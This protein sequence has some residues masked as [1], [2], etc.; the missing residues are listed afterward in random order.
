MNYNK[1]IVP[2]VPWRQNL[3]G[4]LGMTVGVVLVGAL[5]EKQLNFPRSQPYACKNCNVIFI[6]LDTLRA[7]AL[8]CQGYA[9]NT[10]PNL[11]AFAKKNIFFSNAYS[12]SSYTLSSTFSLFTSRIPTHHNMIIPHSDVLDNTISTLPQTLKQLGYETMYIGPL[13]D[14]ALPL[15]RGFERGFDS[16]IRNHNTEGWQKGYDLLKKNS[17]LGKPTFIFFHTY[18]THEP[19][20]PGEQDRTLFTDDYIPGIATSWE[21]FTKFDQT[22]LTYVLRDI[23][24]RIN[25]IPDGTPAPSNL[26]TIQHSLQNARNLEEAEQIFTSLLSQETDSYLGQ[27]Y[28]ASIN[29]YD[30]RHVAYVRAM[31]DARINQLDRELSNLFQLVKNDAISDR[32]IIVLTSDHGEEFMEHGEMYHWKN[33][34]NTTTHVPLIIRAPNTSPQTIRT[35]AQ[36]IDVLPTLFD[37]LGIAI[38]SW[39]EGVSFSDIIFKTIRGIPN[40][41][42][43]SEYNNGVIRSIRNTKWKLYAHT[44]ESPVRFELYDMGR[45]PTEQ[46]DVSARYPDIVKSL[47]RKLIADYG[48]IQPKQYH[49]PD[50]ID[51][52][53]REKLIREGYF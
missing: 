32:T 16:F 38:P 39:A 47:Y 31:Y 4:I 45:D 1:R 2:N 48:N 8:P 20:V 44:T 27:R 36:G 11:C 7:D 37:L 17:S 52:Q 10:A 29:K 53:K 25:A 3:M 21:E 26:V 42:I 18:M 9:R 35:L 24:S 14:P 40:R 28:R 22:L 41:H 13:D 12:Q 23:T 15:D 34:Y 19:Y 50:W 51:E 43:F 49:F 46:R 5:M 30:R 6:S 33:I